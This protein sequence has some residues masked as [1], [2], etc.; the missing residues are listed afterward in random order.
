M[1]APVVLHAATQPTSSVA[2]AAAAKKTVVH[3]DMVVQSKKRKFIADG[4][5]F[6]ELNEFFLKELSEDGYSGLQI[7]VTPQRT[8]VLIYCTKTKNVLGEKGRRIRELTAVVQ[9][10]FHF[11]PG[12]VELYSERVPDRGLSAAAQA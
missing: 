1:A 2:A 12:K 4:L 10:R 8:E 7:R 3:R 11:E 9:N 5:L 6:S